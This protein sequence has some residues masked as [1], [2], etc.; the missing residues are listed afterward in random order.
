M[1][2]KFRREGSEGGSYVGF[3]LFELAPCL[4]KVSWHK[5]L[6]RAM[7]LQIHLA[8]WR[9]SGSSEVKDRRD[10]DSADTRT[11]PLVILASPRIEQT[12]YAFQNSC[13]SS[14]REDRRS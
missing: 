4:A 9:S 1:G 10:K 13:Q 2:E 8:S 7:H 6:P 14:W 11:H 3:S 12:S 5:D